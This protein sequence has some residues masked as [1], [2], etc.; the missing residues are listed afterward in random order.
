[1]AYGRR[2]SS[3]GGYSSRG[4]F[5]RR[6]P[7][8]RR[9]TASRGRRTS[10]RTASRSRGQVVRLVIEQAPASGVSRYGMNPVPGVAAA[11][12]KKARL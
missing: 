9:S 8:R 4:S 5:G 2:S 11:P 3:R 1:M 7:A 6:A 12:T 10:G